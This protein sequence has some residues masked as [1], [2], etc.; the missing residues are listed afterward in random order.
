MMNE[1]NIYN[2]ELTQQTLTMI[3]SLLTITHQL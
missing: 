1:L 2:I 3:S